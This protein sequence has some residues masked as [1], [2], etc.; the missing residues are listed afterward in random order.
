MFDISTRSEIIN[1]C[2]AQIKLYNFGKRGYANG[3]K[4]QQL[5]GIIGQ[6]VISELFGQGWVD[7]SKGFDNGIDIVYQNKSIDVKTMGRT[8][9]V[10]A[11]Y[12]N[13]F[14]GAQ[15]DF[16]T[17]IYIFSSFNKTNN[18]LTVVGWIAKEDFFNKAKFYKRGSI[19]LRSN[20]S[21]FKTFADLYEIENS[22]LNQ[23]E[24]IN[25][26]KQQISSI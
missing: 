5:T 9:E 10:R 6:S 18:V 4:D 11:Y 22:K 12:V 8:T 2:K 15:K 21:K 3:N 1:H 19:R 26:L 7:G 17:D 23:I 20:G 13:N 25:D 24:S 16:S 14:L